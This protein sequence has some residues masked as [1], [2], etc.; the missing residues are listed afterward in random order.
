MT[1]DDAEQLLERS[2]CQ[3]DSALPS[4]LGLILEVLLRLDHSDAAP[5]GAR[6]AAEAVMHRYRGA[7]AQPFAYASLL[8]AARFAAPDAVHV[9]LLAESPEAAAE[10][11]RPVRAARAQLSAPLSLHHAQAEGPARAIVCRAQACSA[12]FTDTA[13]LAEAL[14]ADGSIRYTDR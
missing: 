2:E 4:G 7:I 14:P 13:A 3:H 11:A 10:L 8:T 6:A 1:A 5:A 12:P 9:T